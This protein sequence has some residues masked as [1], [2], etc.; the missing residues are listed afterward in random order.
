ML[1]GLADV[2]LAFTVHNNSTTTPITIFNDSIKNKIMKKYIL[3]WLMFIVEFC[4]VSPILSGFRV[5]RV[6]RHSQA[7]NL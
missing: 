2:I 3:I 6:Q 7:Y 5:M 4:V 1:A